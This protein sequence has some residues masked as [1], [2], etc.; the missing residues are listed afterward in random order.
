MHT[1]EEISSSRSIT[2]LIAPISSV[3]STNDV[4]DATSSTAA[5][6]HSA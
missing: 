5:L 3:P 2:E 6:Q 1:T 4:S